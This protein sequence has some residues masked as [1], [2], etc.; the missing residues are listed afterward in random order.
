VQRRGPR[1]R[2]HRAERFQCPARLGGNRCCSSRS[3]ER[4]LY[5]A[6]PYSPR[7]TR[8]L[9]YIGRSRVHHHPSHHRS[10]ATPGHRLAR[11]VFEAR[12][13]VASI[14]AGSHRR[15]L[16]ERVDV[17]RV[18]LLAIAG[19]IT[20]WP[21][22]PAPQSQLPGPLVRRCSDSVLLAVADQCARTST[23]S[24]ARPSARRTSPPNHEATARAAPARRRAASQWTTDSRTTIAALARRA[25]ARAVFRRRMSKRLRS[26]NKG[27]ADRA[28]H[29]SQDPRLL[30]YYSSLPLLVPLAAHTWAD[31]QE[32]EGA[33][34]PSQHDQRLSAAPATRI[35]KWLRPARRSSPASR[36]LLCR[37]PRAADARHTGV[38]SSSRQCLVRERLA[39]RA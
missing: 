39:V 34:V 12:A 29:W 19:E 14:A 4:P 9:N 10:P 27:A 20:V 28:R 26:L 36:R 13:T 22:D 1:A 25:N 17:G 35:W 7:A 16:P 8:S 23:Q 18:V 11:G 5:H 37:G 6:A 31:V 2:R 33:I 3:L 38:F 15:L 30:L 21:T 32:I 24:A